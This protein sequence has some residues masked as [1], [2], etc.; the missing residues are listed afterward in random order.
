[1][2]VDR[3][4]RVPGDRALVPAAARDRMEDAARDALRI[5]HVRHLQL[6]VGG[7]DAARADAT[8]ADPE[9][10]ALHAGGPGRRGDAVIHGE[11]AA[12]PEVRVRQVGLDVGVGR[13]RGERR[14]GRAEGGRPADA[15]AAVAAE[16]RPADARS[17]RTDVRRGA[18]VAVVARR[19][20]GG[21][22][23]AHPGAVAGGFSEAGVRA[24]AGR[25]GRLELARRVAAVAGHRVAV[26][27]LL[28]GLDHAVAADRGLL[29]QDGPEVRLD[30]A[31]R[32]PRPLDTEEVRAARA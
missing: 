24:R 1:R 9:E 29:A 5:G 21:A 20:G 28:A 23:A 8:D 18:G 12:R 15:H 13:D 17:A 2:P 6:E 27:A 26:V 4:L 14:I 7:G 31:G 19:H 22:A 3:G 16:L 11:E 32:Q 10:G 25:A 30:A